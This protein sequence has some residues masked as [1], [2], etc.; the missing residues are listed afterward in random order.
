MAVQTSRQVGTQVPAGS[1]SIVYAHGKPKVSLGDSICA[2]GPT[3][4]SEFLVALGGTCRRT[5]WRIATVRAAAGTEARGS[6][7]EA[8]G[9]TP[10]RPKASRPALE[11][12]AGPTF[13]C[14]AYP[15][16]RATAGAKW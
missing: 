4:V 13:K 3:A 2:T 10:A 8:E 5:R 14:P 9:E 1:A 15:G 11:G 7:V 12:G 6:T 16:D